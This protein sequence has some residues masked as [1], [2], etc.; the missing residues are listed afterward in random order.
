M[1]VAMEKSCKFLKRHQSVLLS[2]LV[3]TMDV[4]PLGICSKGDKP[5]CI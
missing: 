1:R 5:L 2:N 4:Q 3:L